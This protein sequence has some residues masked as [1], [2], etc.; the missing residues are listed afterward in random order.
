M[1]MKKPLSI[2]LIINSSLGS[3]IVL[4]LITASIGLLAT[5]RMADSLDFLRSESNDIREGIDQSVKSLGEIEGQVKQLGK[6]EGAFSTL[7]ELE[8]ELKQVSSASANIDT[9]LN[10][11][12]KTAIK[13]NDSLKLLDDSTHLLAAQ[14]KLMSTHMRKLQH[15]AQETQ[16]YILHAYLSY[17][18]FVN[19]SDDAIKTAKEDTQLVFRNIGSITKTLAKVNAPND[20]RR[21]TVDIKKS[22]RVYSN[23]FSRLAKINGNEVPDELH[24]QVVTAGRGLLEMSSQLQTAIS[25]LESAISAEATNTAQSAERASASSTAVSTEAQQVLEHSLKLVHNSNQKMGLF[26]ENLSTA[27]VELGTS[28]KTIPQV[29]AS[30][31][32]SVGQMKSFVSTDDITRLEEADSRAKNAEQE[33]E[34]IPMILFGV[35]ILAIL[36]CAMLALFVYRRLV[37]PLSRFIVGVKQVTQND[38]SDTVDD[39]GSLGELREVILGLN[40]LIAALRDNVNDMRSAGLEIS[41]NAEYF[42]ES[43]RNSCQS[44]ETQKNETRTMTLATE[45]L[46]SA[47]QQMSDSAEAASEAARAA[48][49]AVGTGQVTVAE[50]RA[51]SRQLSEKIDATYETMQSLKKDSDN[52]GSVI[53]VIRNIAEQ[54]NLLALNAAI[55]AARAGESGR[56]FAV[57]ADEVRNLANNTSESVNQIEKLIGR[58]QASTEQ[59]ASSIEAGRKQVELNVIASESSKQALIRISE[60]VEMINNMNQQIVDSTKQQLSTVESLNANVQNIH[61]L[62]EETSNTAQKHA[63]SI[64]K[65]SQTADDLSKLVDRFEL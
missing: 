57:V 39:T 52:I 23:L 20:T 47:T 33:A 3:V 51:V 18:E 54:T 29:S 55:E 62:A 44:L 22:I 56:G 11:L 65:L 12:S 6:S 25:K 15:D 16:Y 9:A 53:D 1:V 36:L 7:R 35:S 17:F 27:L 10:N 45:A 21:L 34:M 58:L 13:Q 41:A 2:S 60:S 63:S 48:S 14:L 37:K 4:L 32:R 50:S 5:W 46:A 59:G 26:T 64:V 19:G 61:G 42:Q 43:S 31:A 24:Q 8:Q 38:L 28:L 49:E 40:S 30:V